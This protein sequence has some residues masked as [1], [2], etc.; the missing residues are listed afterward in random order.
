MATNADFEVTWHGDHI[1]T[2]ITQG[3]VAGLNLAAYEVQGR[4]QRR[5]PKKTGALSDSLIIHQATPEGLEAAVYSTLDYAVYQH[6]IFS[7]RRSSGGPKFLEK[8]ALEY[9]RAFRQ[10]VG[11]TI[12]DHAA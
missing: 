7:Y 12:R 10:L 11:K 3:C 6:E 9:E 2:T 1:D 8:A 4:A 5:T